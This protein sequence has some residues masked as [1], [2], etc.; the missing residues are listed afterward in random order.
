MQVDDDT[1]TYIERKGSLKFSGGA[2]LS[3]AEKLLGLLN[4]FPDFKPKLLSSLAIGLSG[5]SQS[6][7]QEIYR[8][9]LREVLGNQGLPIHIESDAT[10]AFKTAVTDDEPG[11]LLVAGT[12]TALLVRD[13]YDALHLIGGWG[14][15]L[16]DEGSGYW[17]GI[18]ALK[19]VTRAIDNMIPK[20]R[21]YE[22][23][24]E[25]L[26]QEIR[27]R[28]RMLS[29]RI[30]SRSLIPSEIAPLVFL[31]AS[32]DKTAKKIIQTA[33]DHLSRL[34]RTGLAQFDEATYAE[35]YVTGSIVK[36]PEMHHILQ[37]SLHDLPIVLR[38]VGNRSPAETA[39]VIAKELAASGAAQE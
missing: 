39:L 26:P 25:R 24:M 23:V 28:P 2:F 33:A 37:R 36:Q 1:P 16:G 31:V 21:L 10:L 11:M 29:R 17:I 14:T 15:V 30:D 20:D 35:L 9:A 6:T 38:E 34:V 8:K 27:D 4:Q 19:H 7:E 5:A 32:S 12:G 13:N 22:A 3:S 18:E